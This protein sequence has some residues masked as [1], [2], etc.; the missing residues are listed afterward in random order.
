MATLSVKQFLEAGVHYGH[1]T[2]RWN[3]RMAPY[4]YG[5]RKGIHIIDLR[6]TLRGIVKARRFLHELASAREPVLFVG[7]KRAA[8]A[9][10][11]ELVTPRGIPY[12]ADRW[13]GGMLTNFQTVR[14]SLRRLEELEALEETGAI[15]NYSKKMISALQREKRKILRNLQGVRNLNRLPAALVVVDP[16]RDRIAV[17]EAVRL[18][19]P[20]VAVLDTDCDPKDIAI[21]IPC[22]DDSIR[23]IQV[24]LIHLV[25]AVE[26]GMVAAESAAAEPELAREMPPPAQ[27]PTP[28]QAPSPPPADQPEGTQPQEG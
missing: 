1:R 24:V 12:V 18:E 3:P 17:Q 11:R 4:I 13:L 16:R 6:Q 10:V 28:Q 19:I 22:N 14:R 27:Q 7:T 20:V 9:A 23:S 5:K 21:P 26:Q 2:S 25:E 8:A 15:Q